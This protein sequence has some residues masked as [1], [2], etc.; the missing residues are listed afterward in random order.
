MSRFAGQTFRDT[1]GEQN[2][3]ED[4]ETCIADTLSESVLT[5]ELTR[6]E[7][8]FTLLLHG[9]TIVAYLKTNVGQAQTDTRLPDALEVERIYVDVAQQGRGYGRILLAEAQAQAVALSLRWMW[10]GVWENNPGAIGFYTREGFEIFDTHVF[11]F[12]PQEHRD[13]MMRR[14]VM[15]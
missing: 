13:H 15:L 3:V 8:A 2:P 6:S 4:V 1:Y 11:Q 7:S 5:K 12:G 10:L 9:E 14:A